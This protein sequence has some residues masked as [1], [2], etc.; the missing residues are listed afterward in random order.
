MERVYTEN[1]KL[2]SEQVVL[3]STFSSNG[4]YSGQ[5]MTSEKVYDLTDESDRIAL[6]RR[7]AMAILNTHS[8]AALGMLVTET[9][10]AIDELRGEL[11]FC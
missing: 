9:R 6:L 10:Q 1:L 8:D 2:E 11:P 7:M 5:D 3:K 4:K